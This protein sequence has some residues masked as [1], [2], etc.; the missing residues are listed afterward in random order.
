MKLKPLWEGQDDKTVYD[1][2]D[3][4]DV[5]KEDAIETRS[6]PQFKFIDPQRLLVSCNL[7]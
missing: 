4:K 5:A 3:L 1:T 6:N 2:P 7:T